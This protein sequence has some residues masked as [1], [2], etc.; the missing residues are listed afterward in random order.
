M[1]FRRE[2]H[3]DPLKRSR[4]I[5]GADPFVLEQ[6]AKAQI[7]AW[8]GLWERLSAGDESAHSLPR[9]DIPPA[10]AEEGQAI[11]A[12]LT[13]RARQSLRA[14]GKILPAAGASA[15]P[16]ESGPEE[17]SEPPP[18]A[19]HLPD[20]KPK[21]SRT[22][23]R[24]QPE[25]SFVDRLFPGRRKARE[26]EVERRFQAAWASWHKEEGEVREV[27]AAYQE[28][29]EDWDRRRL[30]FDEDRRQVLRTREQR[31]ERLAAGDAGFVADHFSSALSTAEL[32]PEIPRD[33]SVSFDSAT[34]ILSVDYRLPSPAD[35]PSLSEVRFRDAQSD[36]LE[37]HLSDADVAAAYDS[38]VY[39]VVLQ[40]LADLF[41]AD[42]AS[43]LR[44][45][46]FNGWLEAEDPASGQRRSIHTVALEVAR[47]RFL[48]I[49]LHRV[50]PQ[51]CF[52]GLGG[53]CA[54]P[55]HQL[56]PILPISAGAHPVADRS[57]AAGPGGRAE[58]AAGSPIPPP[59]P[60]PPTSGQPDLRGMGTAEF[61]HFM[62][63][64]I[65]DELVPE[66]GDLQVTILRQDGS[67]EAVAQGPS[68]SQGGK[69]VLHVI[70]SGIAIERG[71]V[72][73]LLKRMSR[74]KAGRGVL[75]TTGLFSQDALEEAKG[76]SVSLMDGGALEALLEHHEAGLRAQASEKRT[77][78][79]A[80]TESL[81]LRPQ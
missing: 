54:G 51:A 35:L 8:D 30:E 34:G 65:R 28:R 10:S 73:D 29:F 43:R 80:D 20:P 12:A 13:E 52:E 26:A 46:T 17:F 39:Q 60:S 53:Q 72:L 75:L 68:Q 3:H 40:V 16:S 77:G 2:V 79:D 7:E 41:A 57:R 62:V 19:P 59:P 56:L 64:V 31:R 63:Q 74:E 76:K 81:G 14:L 38:V 9:T 32:P 11:A 36:Y 4:L 70:P 50:S 18:K 1:S 21:P 66:T 71:A 37:V 58:E 5:E 45:V 27:L 78:P 69:V 33:A 15:S 25:L 22:E 42:D 67:L 48:E 61:Q 23:A 44:A 6:R 24:F 47:D 49:Q 55:P